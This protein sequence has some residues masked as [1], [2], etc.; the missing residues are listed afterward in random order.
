VGAIKNVGGRTKSDDDTAAG[1]GSMRPPS[2]SL[3]LV[4]SGALRN[5][6]PA[7][8]GDDIRADATASDATGPDTEIDGTD[9][10][11]IPVAAIARRRAGAFQAN[12]HLC[13]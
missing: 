10:H 13:P 3:V 2:K 5:G 11:S 7:C 9:T 1:R 4:A 8:A 12:G 6:W